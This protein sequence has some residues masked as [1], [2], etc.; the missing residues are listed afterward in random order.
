VE[1]P[2]PATWSIPALAYDAMAARAAADYPEETCGLVFG[3]G[4]RLEVVA[5][6]NIQN[7]LHR[8]DPETH[9]RNARTAYVF[10]PGALAEAISKHEAAGKP[11]RAIYHSHP[12][13]DAYFSETD[14]REAAPPEWGEPT[15]PGVVYLVFSVYD[16]KLRAVAGFAWSESRKGF[17]ELKV[18][19]GEPP[20]PARPLGTV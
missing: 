7:E 6:P 11:L 19:R 15:Y 9:P 20:A 5:L 12:D 8:L 17:T 18:A 2:P 4:D 1:S 13:H 14:R 3:E 10:D 16:R